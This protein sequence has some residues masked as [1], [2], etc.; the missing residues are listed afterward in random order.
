MNLVDVP[1]LNETLKFLGDLAPSTWY[2]DCDVDI[3]IDFFKTS[4]RNNYYNYL[5]FKRI[6]KILSAIYNLHHCKSIPIKALL[7]R[8][9]KYKTYE[10]PDEYY[11]YIWDHDDE[12]FH[13]SQAY[14]NY[15]T[16]EYIG[17]CIYKYCVPLNEALYLTRKEIIHKMVH[18]YELWK[19]Y[20]DMCEK[21]KNY[22]PEPNIEFKHV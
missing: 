1:E 14:L 17:E 20:S 4:S 9:M 7:E 13:V 12:K 18:A 11:N 22:D 8:L 21:Y 6:L 10:T 15:K 19:Q 3:N 16:I 2:A 5:E